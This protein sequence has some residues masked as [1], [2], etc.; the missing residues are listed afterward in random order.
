MIKLKYKLAAN[1]VRKQFGTGDKKRDEGQ[2]TPENIIRFDNIQYGE[3]CKFKKWQLLDVYRP[4]QSAPNEDKAPASADKVTASDNK[5]PKLPVIVIVHGGGWVYGDKEVYQFY[6]MRLAQRGF[7][8]VNYSYR[9]A[10]EVKFPASL[11]DTEKVFQWICDN[12]E[13]YGFDTQN[14]FAVGDSAGGHLLS[15]YAS[16]VTNEAYAKNF[17]FIQ[18]KNL[19]LR[20]VG[21][22]CGVYEMSYSADKS[23][24]NILIEALMPK[25]GTKEELQLINAIAH[26]TNAFPPAFIMTAKGDF[27][28]TQ[29]PVMAKALTAA[30]VPH[31]Y[32]C[33]GTDEM[34]LWH[35]FHCDPRL[36]EAVI[37]ND[38]ECNFFKSLI[39]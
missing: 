10:P 3:D 30:G 27:L 1:K 16:A 26:I 25:G 31:E 22:N 38:D 20:G 13:Q 39:I 35:V 5:A 14:V 33:Y 8:V 11:Q 2:T 17:P 21:L 12:A 6:G 19:V 18:K 7:A 23:Q 4:K 9:L 32:K 37:C 15:L 29:G 36:P 24:S 34:P 28:V